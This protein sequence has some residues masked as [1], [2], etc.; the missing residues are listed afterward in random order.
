MQEKT[1][2]RF[3]FTVTWKLV[4]ILAVTLTALN[5]YD[6]AIAIPLIQGKLA[7]EMRTE[8]QSEVQTAYGTLQCYYD[9]ETS[10]T[11]TKSD[12]QQSA[13]AAISGLSYGAN[14]Q[15][16]FWITDSQPVL[17]ADP[18]MPSRIG[19]AVGALQDANG[20]TLF[21]DMSEISTTKGEGFYSYKGGDGSSD[22]AVPKIAYVKSFGPW[23]W[24]IGTAVDVGSL[25]GIGA[26]KWTLGSIGGVTAA[27]VVILFI[28]AVRIVI[29]KPLA[30]MVKT[31]KALAEGNI[32][33]EIKVK[34]DDEVGD[35]GVAYSKVVDYFRE[36]AGI[37]KRIA[38]GDLTVEIKPRSAE[39]V[40]SNS[41]AQMA[42]NQRQL[43]GKVKGTALS[44]A[45]A[46]RQLTK[47]SEQTAQA[48]Q[49]ISSTIQQVA[50]GAAEQ[51]QSL[52]QTVTGVEHL[53]SAIDQIAD[54]A[55]EQARSVNKAS[56][57]V[58][59]VSEA[60]ARVSTNAKAGNEESQ[61][62]AVSAADGARKAHDTVEGM[63]KI[64][65]A[66]ELV[67]T[68]IADLG[69]RS[70]E[71]GRIVETID[72]IAAQTNLLALNAA[73]EA[74]RAGE[75]G[76]GFAVVAD[77]VRKLA[78]R[79]SMAT[80][81]ITQL[82]SGTQ[83]GVREAVHAMQQG[84]NEVEVGYRLAADAGVALDDILSRSQNVGRQVEQISI[85]ALQLQE[86]S[87]EMV[88]A[89]DGINRVVEQN[90]AST[91]EMTASS[92]AV[93]RAMEATAGVAEENSAA[94]EQVSA[95]VQEMSAQIEE[96]LASAQS[97]TD[98]SRE[99]ENTVNVFK[100]GGDG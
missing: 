21:A 28:L 98:T 67:S 81:E 55:Q 40:L 41:F 92:G 20:K 95:S 10:G 53:S 4:I 11:L 47:A 34:S 93:S 59:M 75:Q 2:S 82:V 80:R 86:L 88:A 48:T 99:L 83:S 14:G 72:D 46:S 97:L 1:K 87:S 49:L 79:S 45:D 69:K 64:K 54:G 66:M 12:A 68:R 56:A 32:N 58:N 76:R 70:E 16:Y 74:A 6:Y 65:D 96:M 8:V 38:D 19:T 13:L 24:T 85:A 18:S 43:I 39:D 100:T 33:Q 90:T 36:T 89:I 15:G 29:I 73:I 71:I 94:S 60:V 62:T 5:L 50:K 3:R 26:N 77:E 30:S 44:V 52:Q 31:S 22:G 35:L 84:S 37:T 27:L 57:V 78:E 91:R 23:G 17:L 61:S 7:S 25:S 9:L 63:N 42:A 51:S